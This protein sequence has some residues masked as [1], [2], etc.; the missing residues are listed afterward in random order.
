M[1]LASFLLAAATLASAA[2]PELQEIKT[3]YLLPMTNSLDQFLAIRLTKG[4][5]LQVVTD[6]EKADAVMS[7]HIGAGL[8]DKLQSMYGATKHESSE[9]EKSFASVPMQGTARSK[10]AIF[11]IDRKSRSVIWSDYER[12]KTTHP[13]DLHHTADKIASQ[14]EKDKKA[15]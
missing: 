6:P 4:G 8:E 12:P 9:K 11:L 14:L 7:D 15:K 1:K 10:G 5:V 3:V 2:N 13:G